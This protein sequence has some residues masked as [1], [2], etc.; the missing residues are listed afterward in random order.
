MKQKICLVTCAVDLGNLAIE[1]HLGWLLDKF[2][3]V[4]H[5][6]FAPSQPSFCTKSEPLF[7][8]RFARVVQAP[9]L[10]QRLYQARKD[11]VPILIYSLNTATHAIPFATMFPSSFSVM[12]DW[13]RTLRS[14]FFGEP[15]DDRGNVVLRFQQMVLSKAFKV[16]SPTRV[17][18]EHLHRQ[19]LVPESK[20]VKVLMPI[21]LEFFS[22]SQSLL[23][24]SGGK[25]R[26]VFVGGE[27]VKKGGDILLDWYHQRGYQSCDLT[28]LTKHPKPS[29]IHPGVRWETDVEWSRVVEIFRTH[30]VLC[31]PSRWDAF[32]MVIGEAAAA[33]LAVVASRSA[34]G[35]AEIIEDGVSGFIAGS[36]EECM[37]AL[38]KLGG[39]NELVHR[40]RLAARKLMV[41]RYAPEHVFDLIAKALPT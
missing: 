18:V 14:D 5:F 38:D 19:Y 32:G 17:C 25:T 27:F 10:N 28:V 36:P 3:T 20:L 41:E 11:S 15:L 26:V 30:Q 1:K 22:P 40:M 35:S 29:N 33:G 13:T 16:L 2:A 34:L 23:P 37:L 12:L 8:T 9:E 24:E 6:H 4:D 39:S 7:K 31:L 21:D